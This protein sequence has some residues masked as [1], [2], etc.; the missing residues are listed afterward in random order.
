MGIKILEF[1][2]QSSVSQQF[3]HLAKFSP[4]FR[5]LL[6]R[7]IVL[8]LDLLG[9]FA[10]RV[11]VRLHQLY[12]VCYRTKE[13]HHKSEERLT[14]GCRQSRNCGICKEAFCHNCI[15]ISI[16]CATDLKFSKS[17]YAVPV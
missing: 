11:A 13:R 6:G 1:N 9:H 3:M 15:F 17:L 7:R 2:C 16:S 5:K 12:T 4:M 10:C 14:G 8:V